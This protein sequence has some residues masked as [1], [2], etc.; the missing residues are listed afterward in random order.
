[1]AKVGRNDKCPCGSDQK[2]KKCCGKGPVEKKSQNLNDFID[3]GFERLSK[4][5][6]YLIQNLRGVAKV[7]PGDRRDV[8]FESMLK[9][10]VYTL[11]TIGSLRQPHN[12][13]ARSSM[14]TP[15]QI[16]WSGLCMRRP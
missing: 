4:I 5:T 2:F 7:T 10:S 1:M 8:D 14:T 13:K 11:S 15:A 6:Y 3:L 12:T 16:R 9:K